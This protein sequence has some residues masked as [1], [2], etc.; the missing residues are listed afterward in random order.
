MHSLKEYKLFFQTRSPLILSPRSSHAFYRDALWNEDDV[1]FFKTGEKDKNGAVKKDKN[2][3]VK[4]DEN[5]ADK[6]YNIIYPFY[7]YGEYKQFNPQHPAR[8][9]PGSSIKGAITAGTDYGSKSLSLMVDDVTEFH[10]KGPDAKSF[11]IIS[12]LKSQY[13]DQLPKLSDWEARKRE[14]MISGKKPTDCITI[15]KLLPFFAGTVGLE[16]LCDDVEFCV[17]IRYGGNLDEIL[18]DTRQ[19]TIRILKKYLAQLNDYK[20][21]TEILKE[22]YPDNENEVSNRESCQ[23]TL[24]SLQRIIEHTEALLKEADTKTF[25][26]MGGYKGLMRSLTMSEPSD[27]DQSAIFANAQYQPFGYIEIVNIETAETEER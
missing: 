16:A 7:R 25:R 27:P 19:A 14:A 6:T 15:P 24:E 17:V 20:E 12:P 21:R 8:Y 9:I 11:S 2:G 22:Q 3:A 4:T 26:F 23:D 13:F 10:A 5:G 18:A 1:K